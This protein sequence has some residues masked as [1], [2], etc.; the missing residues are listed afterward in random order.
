M[1]DPRHAKLADL[2]VNYST[3]VKPGQLVRISGSY[4]A[5]PL[6]TELTRAVYQAGAHPM[7]RMGYEELEEIALKYAT[8]D[9]LK[10]VNPVAQSEV[11]KIDVHIGLWAEGNTRHLTQADPKRLA[12]SQSSRKPIFDVFMRRAALGELKWVGTQ[13]PTPGCAQDAEMSL[14]EYEDFVF[15]AGLLNDPDPVASWRRVSQ[16]QQRLVDFLNGKRDYR[17]VAANGTDIRMSVTDRVWLNCD[18]HE[19]FPDGE[20]FTGPV[21]DSVDGHIH[22]SFPAVHLGREVQDARLTFRHGKV[23]DAS[24]AKG[25]DFLLQMLDVDA[26]AR[27]MGECAIGTNFGITRYTKNT[28]FDEKIGG[29]VHFAIGA[30]YPE[31]G[32]TNESGLHWDMVVDLRRGGH[33]EID[34]HKVLVDGKFTREDWPAAR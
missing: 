28:L 19:N 18:G 2:L 20:V 23:V 31:T 8:D 29:T 25:E 30:G 5:M 4:L 15:G 24:A 22:F 17:V 34:G 32:N 10:Y 3:G 7:L 1:R 26:G 12:I 9:Q 16:T 33:V 21:L 6:L 13:Y 27:F 11:E 14:S